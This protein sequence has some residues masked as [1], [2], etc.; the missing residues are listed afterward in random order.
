MADEN[1]RAENERLR[2]Q[3]E[4]LKARIRELE[5]AVKKLSERLGMN[6]Q[7]SSMPPSSDMAHAGVAQRRRKPTGRK[8]GGQ[9]GHEGRMRKR[10]APQDIDHTE[11]FVPKRCRCCGV[12]L[13]GKA[14]LVEA[15]QV[16]DVPP[17][18][19]EVTEYRRYRRACTCG[20]VTAATFPAEVPDACVGPRLQAI[21]STLSGRYRLSRREVLDAIVCL[22]GPKA[23]VSLGTVSALEHRSSVALAPV[24][25]Q[26]LT[27]LRQAAVSH[28]D[29][30]SWR[31]NKGKAWLWTGVTK[32]LAV[33][34]V[35][36]R[37]SQ[38][39]FHELLGN[40][41]E[42][43]IETDRWT[44]YHGHS[45][46]RRQLCWAHLKRNFQALTEIG[47]KGATH[48]GRVGLRAAKAVS[49][50]WR[51]HQEGRV[52]HAKLRTGLQRIRQVLRRAL[53]KGSRSTDPKTA[54][55]SRDLRKHFLS[56]WTFMR[57]EE[58]EPTNNRA[59]RALRKGVLWRKGS[60]GSDSINGARF[61]ERMLTVSETLRL[62]GRNV[63]DFIEAAIR[64]HL[65]G[66]RPPL[67]L[68][69][70]SG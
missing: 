14:A 40:N 69:A 64:S 56:L 46:W 49:E 42:G 61:A 52:A 67:L 12:L 53:G 39:A 21:M 36:R 47:H 25:A 27:T 33:F 37:R 19:A 10:F 23:K 62:Q 20:A 16:V 63:V 3:N 6:S 68:N 35:H 43:V 28:V 9:R 13:G 26:A 50:I 66:T 34:H 55:L 48:V 2:R 44:S 8:R 30:T 65:T 1:L 17:S 41:Y 57:I 22:Y 29:E 32:T 31:Q 15:H 24:H 70:S 11:E 51:G 60:F 38:E 54:A 58:V 5:A 45:R 18:V 59:E 4:A 7:N